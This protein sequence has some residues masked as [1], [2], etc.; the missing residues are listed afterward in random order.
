MIPTIAPF[1]LPRLLVRFIKRHPPIELKTVEDACALPSTGF[2]PLHVIRHRFRQY[3][4]YAHRLTV[5]PTSKDRLRSK[6]FKGC[7]EELNMLA[8][9]LPNDVATG[10]RKVAD[11]RDN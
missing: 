4:A 10:K 1:F 2:R 3:F 8:L 5:R 6:P 9:N 7:A 11:A